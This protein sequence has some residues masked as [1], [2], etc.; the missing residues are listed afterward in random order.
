MSKYIIMLITFLL[1]LQN[2][3]IYG[4]YEQKKYLSLIIIIIII[5]ILIIIKNKSNY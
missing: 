3:R 5:I 1:P 2:Q 4:I